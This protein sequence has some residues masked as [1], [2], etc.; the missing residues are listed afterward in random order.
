MS[1][2]PTKAIPLFRAALAAEPAGPNTAA[3]HFLLARALAESGEEK[4]A[5]D[6]FDYAVGAGLWVSDSMLGG[7]A[8]EELQDHPRFIDIKRK[9]AN[10]RP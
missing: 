4:A 8:F 3:T 10:N 5:L 1:G 6:E 9:M 2:D 7:S